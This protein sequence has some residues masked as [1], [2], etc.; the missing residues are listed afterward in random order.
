MT[1][2]TDGDD[3]RGASARDGG[4][5]STTAV[6]VHRGDL[7]PSILISEGRSTPRRISSAGQKRSS[8]QL[9]PADGKGSSNGSED[10]K[11]DGG[12]DNN[13]EKVQLVTVPRLSHRNGLPES[14]R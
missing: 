5:N 6:P 10:P 7:L 3:G 14:R 8:Q 2:P 9:P 12:L 13:K 1:C 11:N 4:T